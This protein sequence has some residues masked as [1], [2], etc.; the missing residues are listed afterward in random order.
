MRRRRSRST[1][2]SRPAYKDINVVI[3][4]PD[5]GHKITATRIARHLKWPA[6]QPVGAEQFEIVGVRVRFE[7][8]SRYSATLEPSMLALVAAKP[9]QT[10][11]PTT[12]FKGNWG[13]KELVDGR[14]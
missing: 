5:L 4:D 6:G 9:K 10:V 2:P 1:R 12:E 3:N 14:P 7:P 8:G 11:A 13:A